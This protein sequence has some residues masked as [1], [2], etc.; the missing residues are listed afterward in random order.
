[1]DGAAG[2]A[3][4]TGGPP[5]RLAELLAGP[6]AQAAPGLLGADL[7][8]HGVRLR[9]TEVEAY[10]GV[11]EDPASHAHGGPTR[12]NEVMFGAAGGLYVYFTYGMHWCAN[13]VVGPVGEAAAVLLRA[14]E[15]REGH[16]LARAR[17]PT[18]RTDRELARGPARLTVALAI[19]GAHNGTPLWGPGP[20]RLR[21]PEHPT[22]AV[23]VCRGPRVGVANGHERAWRFWLADEPTVSGYRRHAPRRR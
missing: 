15:V 2:D 19:D 1:M 12:R 5:D 6:V 13:V 10:G 9:I 18:A 21:L 11:G 7:T 17:R 16:L 14:G 3:E 8:A 4:L 20:V 23:T 22:E